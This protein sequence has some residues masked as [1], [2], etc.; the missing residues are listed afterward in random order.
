MESCSDWLYSPSIE[1][2]TKNYLKNLGHYRYRL[3]IPEYIVI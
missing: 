1:A 3:I 2:I